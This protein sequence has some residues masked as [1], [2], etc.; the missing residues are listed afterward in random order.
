MA[1]GRRIS[2]LGFVDDATLVDIYRK[3]WV[4]IITSTKEGF[5]LTGLEASASGTPIVAYAAPGLETVEH[6]TNG[7]TVP[8]RNIPALA[9]ALCGL[10]TD[11]A[12]RLRLS[13]SAIEYGQQ[14]TWR[15]TADRL[16]SVMTGSSVR[17]SAS[18][19]PNI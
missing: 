12:L 5:G 18:I 7:L 15:E 10:L 1:R 2:V 16:M 4:H 8:V 14:W 19:S 9:E 3:S 17:P 11:H 13:Q 6:G